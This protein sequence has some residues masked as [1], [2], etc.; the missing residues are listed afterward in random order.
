MME[1]GGKV[2]DRGKMEALG[3]MGTER[4]MKSHRNDGGWRKGGG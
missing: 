4:M 2:D 3:M 1:T